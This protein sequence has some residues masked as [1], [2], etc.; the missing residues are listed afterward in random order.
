MPSTIVWLRDDLRLDDNPALADAVALGHP[1]SVVY[2][3]DGEWAGGRPLGGAAKWWLHRSLAGS[4]EFPGKPNV[5]ALET[6]SR[7]RTA[8][9]QPV[10]GC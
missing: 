3:L 4:F 6:T 9:S 1:V 8:D 2:V 7:S 5:R 10:S